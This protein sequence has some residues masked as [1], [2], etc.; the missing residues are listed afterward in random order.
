MLTGR[1]R[2][3]TFLELKMENERLQ[4]RAEQLR[5]QMQALDNPSENFFTTSDNFGAAE[6][7]RSGYD[8]GGAAVGAEDDDGPRKK[9]KRLA[10][11]QHVCVTCGRTDSPEWR[12]VRNQTKHLHFFPAKLALIHVFSPYFFR[13]PRDLKRFVTLVVSV[14]RNARK[15]RERLFGQA[16]YL[17]RRQSNP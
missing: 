9:V 12:K 8:M 16:A 3:N 1:G 17:G 4:Q 15:K 7:T 13:A 14:G 2:L 10:A 6:G 11:E 5:A